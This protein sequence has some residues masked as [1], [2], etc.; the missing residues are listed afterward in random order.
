M[1]N[2]ESLESG[3]KRYRERSLTRLTPCHSS[4]DRRVYMYVWDLVENSE[5]CYS[6]GSLLYFMYVNQCDAK[7]R[8]S[9]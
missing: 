8:R 5:S 1:E 4:N 7:N 3:Y 2:M 9:L 6:Y